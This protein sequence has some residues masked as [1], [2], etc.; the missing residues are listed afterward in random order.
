MDNSGQISAPGSLEAGT[1][2][3]PD[4]PRVPDGDLAK[5]AARYEL[6]LSG[7]RPSLRKYIKALWQRG[8]GLPSWP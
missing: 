5:L 4:K 3:A 1:V 8:H 7:A 6:R 2:I